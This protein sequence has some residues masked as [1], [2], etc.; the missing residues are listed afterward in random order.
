MLTAITNLE[1]DHDFNPRLYDNSNYHFDV[2]EMINLII[3]NGWNRESVIVVGNYDEFKNKIIQGNKRT[4]ALKIITD[5]SK[6]DEL[7]NYNGNVLFTISAQTIKKINNL[8]DYEKRII[9]D[10]VRIDKVK[11]IDEQKAVLFELNEYNG[12]E[13]WSIQAKLKFLS[14]QSKVYPTDLNIYHKIKLLINKEGEEQGFVYVIS[15][16]I[17]NTHNNNLIANEIYRILKA[18]ILGKSIFNVQDLILQIN[19]RG[20]EITAKNDNIVE[21]INNIYQIYIKQN[22]MRVIDR[23]SFILTDMSIYEY[24]EFD[25]ER[26]LKLKNKNNKYNKTK[27]HVVEAIDIITDNYLAINYETF[28][29]KKFEMSIELVNEIIVTLHEM[30]YMYRS[31]HNF[32]NLPYALNLLNKRILDSFITLVLYKNYPLEMVQNI[33]NEHGESIETK[34]SICCANNIDVF[35]DEYDSQIQVN[36]SEAFIADGLVTTLSSLAYFVTSNRYC[37]QMGINID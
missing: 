1:V 10:K 21:I 20:L 24:L 35:V 16:I 36:L 37:Y 3:D 4:C 7:A 23:E 11:S 6:I 31:K 19:E 34:Y 29:N 14:E 2:D 30:K 28:E 27:N 18:K 9:F 22:V 32:E 13:K 17:D 12:H 5:P 15:D 25:E 26:I 33:M 8:T